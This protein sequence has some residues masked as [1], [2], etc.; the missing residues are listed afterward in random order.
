VKWAAIAIVVLVGAVAAV[1]EEPPQPAELATIR[2]RARQLEQHLRDL[3]ARQNDL[4]RRREQLE[5]ELQLAQLRVEESEAQRRD[6]EHLQAE[7]VAAAA[8]SQ[9][10]LTAAVDRLRSQLTLL[11]ALGRAG[12]TPL[13]LRATLGGEDL[14][15]RVTVA[16]ALVREQKSE[17]DRLAEMAEKRASALA[18]LSRRREDLAEATRELEA[19]RADL[20]ATRARVVA[21]F[22]RLESERR[23]SAVALAGAREAEAR[24]DRLWGAVTRDDGGAGGDIKLLRGGLPW[25]VSEPVLVRRFGP[26]RDPRYGTVTVSHGLA[27]EVPAGARVRAIA[28]GKV[29]YAQFFR[30]YGNL[31]I[32]QHGSQVY[33]LYAR[34]GSMLTR[35]G[36]WVAMG[37]PV[38]VA[39]PVGE[40][41]GNVYLEIR[42][43]REAQDPLKWLKPADK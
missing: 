36:E 22:A 19:R 2:E 32:V 1:A 15:H 38:G 7:A 27:F 11:A 23:T 20:E 37:D 25:P 18:D 28:S 6:L 35:A 5:G 3:E 33:S 4:G 16:L 9:R 29:A 34:L 30:G 41:D 24:L 42:V 17:R 14:P 43:G 8:E 21:E 39:G 13:V 10:A 26:L 12:L 40:E 31:V